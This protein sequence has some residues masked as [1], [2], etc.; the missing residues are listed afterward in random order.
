MKTL[1]IIGAVAV[2]A[3]VGFYA[4]VGV[5]CLHMTAPIIQN[6]DECDVIQEQNGRTW[7]MN[8]IHEPRAEL[9]PADGSTFSKNLGQLDAR[10]RADMKKLHDTTNPQLTVQAEELQ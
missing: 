7:C 1:P 6:R 3:V 9:I 2:I 5:A 8:L 4:T 10:S